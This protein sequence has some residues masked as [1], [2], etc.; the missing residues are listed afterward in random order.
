METGPF[1]IAMDI[2]QKGGAY[3]APILLCAL[4]WMHWDRNRL[5]KTLDA[6]DEQIMGL[7]ERV[8]TVATELK[9]YL[10]Q[11]RRGGGH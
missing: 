7:S 4:A 2:A 3:V 8:I 5:L 9:T 10:F 6:K 11:E 1:E